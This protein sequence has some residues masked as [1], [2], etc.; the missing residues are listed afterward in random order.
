MT[1]IL[2]I[3]GY[4][5]FGGR[6]A[7][8]LSRAGH[9]VLVG[10][11]SL[12][13]A[14]AFCE[15]RTGCRPL[16]IDRAGEF[17]PVLAA[18]RP[19][20]VVDAA[21]PFQHSGYDLVEACIAFG[22]AYLDFADARDFVTGIARCHS[23][24]QAAGVPVIAGASSVPALSA[25]VVR[26]LAASLHSVTA[27]EI[28]ISA[29]SR[30]TAGASVAEAILGG[31]GQPIPIW[32]G[33]HWQDGHGWQSLRRESFALAS[34]QSL[35]TRLVALASVPDLDLLPQRFPGLS[36]ISFRAGTESSLANIA[37]WLASWPV[38]WGILRSI[39]AAKKWLLR[40]QRLTALWGGDRSGMIVRVFGMAGELRV[41]RRWTLIAEKGDGP[42]IPTLA[43]ALLI[44]KIAR[45]EVAP[46]ARD[47]GEALTLAE[48]EPLFAQ[49]AIQHA[50]IEIAQPA[51]L[52]RRVM[53]EKF[54]RLAPSLRR[55]HSVLRDDGAHGLGVVTRGRHPLARLV[56]NVMRFPKEGEHALHLHFR[57]T[58]GVE[59][60]TR[61]F[62]GRRFSSTLSERGGE[63]VERFGPLRFRYT[64]IADESGGLGMEMRQ[65]SFFGVRLPLAL[66]PRSPAREWE[67]DGRFHFDVPIDLPLIGRVVHYRGWLGP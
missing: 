49:L 7:R 28:A 19:D 64:L 47:A 57:E 59:H 8:R 29:S 41:E 1:T 36:A 66:A 42:E 25:A 18:E 17:A 15:G 16:R 31:V 50:T 22:I 38:R 67:A 9:D 14:V 58:D 65:W 11:R 3:G 62:G 24:A 12:T 10:G 40:A 63:I 51:A 6:L 46:G 26:H 4:G 54:E 23:V 2:V 55:L 52:Y 61:D 32:Q 33:K 27:I 35:R 45:G 20:I 5:G 37:L 39:R 34:G 44:E 56:A 13:R 53:G 48:F 60:W 30:A 21:G 43:A